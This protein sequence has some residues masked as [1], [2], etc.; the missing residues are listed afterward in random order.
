MADLKSI[1]QRFGLLRPVTIGP[2]LEQGG[3]GSPTDSVLV[4]GESGVGKESILRSSTTKSPQRPY[5][6]VNC[7]AIPEGTIDSTFRSRGPTGHWCA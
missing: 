6:A 5:I 2:C 7:G 3:S 1:K 4:T